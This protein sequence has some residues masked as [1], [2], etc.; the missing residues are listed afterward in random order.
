LRYLSTFSF[1]LLLLFPGRFFVAGKLFIQGIVGMMRQIHFISIDIM[2]HISKHSFCQTDCHCKKSCSF[3]M[4]C[5]ERFLFFVSPVALCISI[6]RWDKLA[7]FALS[8]F[9][10]LSSCPIVKLFLWQPKQ[11]STFI[12]YF[13]L[14]SFHFKHF[15]VSFSPR[16]VHFYRVSIEIVVS[17]SFIFDSPNF[18]NFAVSFEVANSH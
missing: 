1:S 13:F 11:L 14:H 6:D 9:V 18:S 3:L 15:R 5:S 16:I 7:R 2:Q 12:S 10:C 8:S 17:Y 4:P